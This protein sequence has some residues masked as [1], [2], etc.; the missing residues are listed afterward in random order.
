MSC[1]WKRMRNPREQ[2]A[3]HSFH[4]IALWGKS[5]LSL[6]WGVKYIAKR[7]VLSNWVNNH[8]QTV[9]LKFRQYFKYVLWFQINLK[10][11]G[12]GYIDGTYV[13]RYY[14]ASPEETPFPWVTQISYIPYVLLLILTEWSVS[15]DNLQKQGS[16]WNY[17]SK[18]WHG[19][20]VFVFLTSTRRLIFVAQS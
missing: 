18:F 2:T 17:N 10:H 5:N 7:S 15:F 19:I 14:S 13:C 4:Y 16:K 8:W 9:T 12:T 6:L 1:Q 11:G 3:V 20:A